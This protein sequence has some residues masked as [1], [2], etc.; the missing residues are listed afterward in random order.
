LKK[1]FLSSFTKSGIEAV[2]RET[3]NASGL[4]F[5]DHY[6][7]QGDKKT[8][9]GLMKKKNSE[10]LDEVFGCGYDFSGF[11]PRCISDFMGK[12]KSQAVAP[13]Q[14]GQSPVEVS[15]GETEPLSKPDLPEPQ[16]EDESLLD[17]VMANVSFLHHQVNENASS[18]YSDDEWPDDDEPIHRNDY[19]KDPEIEE[20]YV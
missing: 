16:N 14:H 3:V 19:T 6:E 10:I 9:A 7:K 12:D 17:T 1:E 2:L 20:D 4:A 15:T 13:I 11:V 18:G 8:L 5:V